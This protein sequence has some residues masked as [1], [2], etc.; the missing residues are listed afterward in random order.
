MKV[1]IRIV[2]EREEPAVVL[3][4]PALTA[5]A[6]E[7]A[8]QLR[9]LMPETPIL[10]QG[11]RAIRPAAADILR[12]YTEDKGVLAQLADGRV[13]TVRLRLYELEERL[14]GHT[15]VRISHSE[16]VNLRRVTA[17][18]LSITGTIKMHLADG[19]AVCYV[20]RRYV[21]KIRQAL[22]L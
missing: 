18:D 1:E 11:D 2:P 13:C 3:E 4:T 12:F 17:L 6:E 9:A 8:A 7:L 14:D 5:Q 10:W 15:F 16:I 21:K 22:E 20:S 19:A